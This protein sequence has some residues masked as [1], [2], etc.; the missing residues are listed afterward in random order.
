MVTL[1]QRVL[2]VTGCRGGAASFLS[3]LG[4]AMSRCRRCMNASADFER[5]LGAGLYGLPVGVLPI[6]RI[7]GIPSFPP[8]IEDLLR[9]VRPVRFRQFD[10]RACLAQVPNYHVVVSADGRSQRRGVRVWGKLSLLQLGQD[11]AFQFAIER[12]VMLGSQIRLPAAPRRIAQ[13]RARPPGY[14]LFLQV[15]G[16]SFD[17]RAARLETARRVLLEVSVGQDTAQK[18]IGASV[19]SEGKAE[20]CNR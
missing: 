10:M 9:Q 1:E 14:I 18:I 19:S 17:H 11:L 7:W 12:T 2:D 6:F 3:G 4:T 16:H 8:F 20:R 15:D 5:G 13:V